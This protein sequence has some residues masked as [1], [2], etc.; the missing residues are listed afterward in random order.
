MTKSLRGVREIRV[1]ALA[2]S[3]LV[4]LPYLEDRTFQWCG[5]VE[6][7]SLLIDPASDTLTDRQVINLG[8]GDTTVERQLAWFC[9]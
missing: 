5:D 8:S 6:T 1:L 2:I 7:F 4:T 3:R 9:V